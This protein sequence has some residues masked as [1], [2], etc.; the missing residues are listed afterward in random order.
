VWRP[1]VWQKQNFQIASTFGTEQFYFFPIPSIVFF[2]PP[3]IKLN[4]PHLLFA[5][6]AFLPQMLENMIIGQE[7]SGERICTI[8]LHFLSSIQNI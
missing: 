6:F 2:A 8:F 4:I 7:Y 3:F 5:F 1:K